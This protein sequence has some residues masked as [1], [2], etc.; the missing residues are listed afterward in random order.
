M[1]SALELEKHVNQALLDLHKVA[2]SHDDAQMT[3]WLESNYLTEQVR[4]PE[5]RH[6]IG[7]SSDPNQSSTVSWSTQCKQ[8]RALWY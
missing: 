6:V 1:Q 3:D 4:L 7:L 5:S 8:Q 2:S